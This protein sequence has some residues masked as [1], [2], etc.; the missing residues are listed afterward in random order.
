[1]PHSSKL[2]ICSFENTIAKGDEVCQKFCNN[3]ETTGSLVLCLLLS[4]FLSITII[5]STL[6]VYHLYNNK[7]RKKT[8][9]AIQ[10]DLQSLQSVVI[11]PDDSIN[12]TTTA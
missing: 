9:R 5:L 8:S 7:K 11:H 3:E 12:I 10:C 2:L 6:S 4:V 1:M